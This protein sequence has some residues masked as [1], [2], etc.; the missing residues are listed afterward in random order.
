M[1][2]RPGIGALW[3]EK[4]QGDV[5]PHDFLVMNGKKM[6]PPRYYDNRYEIN[7]PSEVEAIKNRRVK[8]SRRYREN[9][10][11]ERLLVR[12]FISRVRVDKLARRL[13]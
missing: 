4:F 11:E 1:S 6:R 2:R 12:E 8:N 7:Y 10:T 3:L 13:K 9:N 5:Y